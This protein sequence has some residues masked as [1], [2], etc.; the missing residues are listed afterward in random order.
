MSFKRNQEGAQEKKR[1]KKKGTVAWG[2]AYLGDCQPSDLDEAGG[3]RPYNLCQKSGGK[4]DA[5]L[6]DS[7]GNDVAEGGEEGP[8]IS[9][10]HVIREIP[11]GNNRSIDNH[12]GTKCKSCTHCCCCFH[13]KQQ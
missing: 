3:E 9:S 13:C 2:D 1:K 8:D 5:L 6:C 4:G 12:I 7:Q 10:Q 11:A